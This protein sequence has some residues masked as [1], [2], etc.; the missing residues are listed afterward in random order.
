MNYYWYSN[1][2]AA[3]LRF[4]LIFFL[5]CCTCGAQSIT[6]GVVGGGRVTDD[7]VGFHTPESNVIS[8]VPAFRPESRFYLVGPAIEVGL[9]HRFSL[10]FDALYH[11]QGFFCTFYDRGAFIYHTYGERDNVWEFP[12]LLKYRLRGRAMNPFVEMGVTPRTMRGRITDISQDAFSGLGPPSSSTYATSYS[13][14]V[15]F[16]SGGGIEFHVGHISLAPQVR[17]TRW[18]ATPVWG[19]DGSRIGGIFSSN[20]NQ[21][22]L[23]V[24][25]NWKLR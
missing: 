3:L 1:C 16:V 9:P 15:G 10:E 24:G 2:T 7:V 19:A 23:L 8:G 6:I 12:V 5:T 21:L 18:F 20:L 4:P 25:I 22:D 14:T 17:Y 11:R 13:P